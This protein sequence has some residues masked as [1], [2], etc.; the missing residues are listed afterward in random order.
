APRGSSVPV[1][2]RRT[3]QNYSPR[4]SAKTFL[5][6]SFVINVP[7]E[8][9]RPNPVRVPFIAGMSGRDKPARQPDIAVESR[10]KLFPIVHTPVHHLIPQRCMRLLRNHVVDHRIRSHLHAP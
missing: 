4:T 8:P 9:S 5:Q 2:S 1:S 3:P 6:N 10:S 7:A